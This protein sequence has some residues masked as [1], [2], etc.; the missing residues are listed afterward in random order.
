MDVLDELAIDH[1]RLRDVLTQL[2]YELVAGNAA[3]LRTMHDIVS[4]YSEYFNRVHHP[5]EDHIFEYM[6]RRGA[7]REHGAEQA[8]KEHGE[9]T[10]DTALFG[11]LLNGALY[12]GIM[13]R[14]EL[15]QTGWR[16][17]EVNLD[18]I[19]RE[20]QTTFVWACKL[21]TDD[22]WAAIA[23]HPLSQKRTELLAT[24]IQN[25][26]ARFSKPKVV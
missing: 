6:L 25:E 23:A 4:H 1:S 24:S 12:D 16:F 17:L 20:E 3:N 9:L 21:L 10:R 14:E 26:C 19:A 22:D 5:L 15:I 2:E 18:H 7:I 11:V 13:A 8:L